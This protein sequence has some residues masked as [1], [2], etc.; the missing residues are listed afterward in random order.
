MI[1]LRRVILL[2]MAVAAQLVTSGHGV[3]DEIRSVA[4]SWAAL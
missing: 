2:I 1:E 4:D 3:A